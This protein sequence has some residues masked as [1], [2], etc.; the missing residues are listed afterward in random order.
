MKIR[1]EMNE[2]LKREDLKLYDSI[3]REMIDDFKD[4]FTD[5]IKVEISKFSYDTIFHNEDE[6]DGVILQVN[7]HEDKLGWCNISMSN[8]MFEV[9]YSCSDFNEPKYISWD[10]EELPNIDFLKKK[11]KEIFKEIAII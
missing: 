1:E 9:E 4:E 3:L 11:L 10:L 8:R 5:K 6:V 7:N 2:S